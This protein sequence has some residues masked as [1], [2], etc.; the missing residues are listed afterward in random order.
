MKKY[1]KY[2]FKMIYLKMIYLYIIVALNSCF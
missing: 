1:E 2:I